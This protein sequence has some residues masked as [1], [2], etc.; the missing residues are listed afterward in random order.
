MQTFFRKALNDLFL[1]KKK[2]KKGRKRVKKKPFSNG[3]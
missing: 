3:G 1:I 2:K